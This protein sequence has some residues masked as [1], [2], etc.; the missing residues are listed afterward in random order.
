MSATPRIRDLVWIAPAVLL[1]VAAGV[2]WTVTSRIYRELASQLALERV[3]VERVQEL[4]RAAAAAHVAAIT[5]WVSDNTR[6]SQRD[7]QTVEAVEALREAIIRMTALTPLDADE[8]AAAVRLISAA[9]FMSNEVQQALYTSDIV[10]TSSDLDMSMATLRAQATSM[11]ASVSRAGSTSDLRLQKLRTQQLAIEIV[12]VAVAL[13]I[14]LLAVQAL[15]QRLRASE[16]M[17]Q[18]ETH[19]AAERAQFFANTSHEL[20]TPLAAIRGF[21]ATI[22]DVGARQIEAHTQELLGIINN[23]LDAS[24]IEAGAMKLTIEEIDVAAV[25]ER[26]VARCRSL[27]GVKPL[28]LLTDV[29]GPLVARGDF[30][31]LQQVITNLVANAIKFTERGRVEVRAQRRA[32]RIEIEVEDT[33]IGVSPDAFERIWQPFVQADRNADRRHGGTGLGL[34]IVRG[35]VEKM[36]GAVSVESELG[37]GS[38]FTVRLAAAAK[39]AVIERAS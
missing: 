29:E 22:E 32:D 5:R 30:V 13:G 16:R 1:L 24:K 31:K 19:A 10:G 8:E 35:L 23:I 12:F 9:A 28:Q 27:I 3:H 25:I 36:G 34:A 26:S 4:E 37:R 21:A 15:L 39:D 6:R 14:V 11:T 33:G 20:R 18:I 17:R 38:C 2:L 7:E